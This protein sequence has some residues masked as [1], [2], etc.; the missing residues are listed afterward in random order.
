MPKPSGDSGAFG[1]VHKDVKK[2]YNLGEI[3]TITFRS[4]NPAN[5]L[6]DPE[7]FI[8]IEKKIDSDSYLIILN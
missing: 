8:F 6:R 3:V 1:K 5:D 4:A 7:T 2:S